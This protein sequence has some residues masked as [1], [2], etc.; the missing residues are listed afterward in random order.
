VLLAFFFPF[1]LHAPRPPRGA[2]PRAP[3]RGPA[4]RGGGGGGQSGA[5]PHPM[6]AD[7]RPRRGSIKRGAAYQ[8]PTHAGVPKTDACT[9]TSRAGLTSRLV[10][11]GEDTK[12]YADTKHMCHIMSHAKYM[13]HL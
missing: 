8:Q 6:R 3:P 2:A 12:T 9:P 5:R 1:P 13:G 7:P 4:Q 10:Y 11:G